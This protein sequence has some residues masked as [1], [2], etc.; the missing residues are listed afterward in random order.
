MTCTLHLPSPTHANAFAC[1][2]PCFKLKP[3]SKCTKSGYAMVNVEPYGGLLQHTW[4][5][6]DLSVAGRVLIRTEEG[7]MQHKLVRRACGLGFRSQSPIS[8]SR[9]FVAPALD[10][11]MP[12]HKGCRAA[13]Q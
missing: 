6:R 2:S 3:V 8:A 7:S 5:D 1:C 13:L 11:G 12:Q 4:F 9:R 10:A